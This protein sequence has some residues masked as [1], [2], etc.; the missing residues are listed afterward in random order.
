MAY[1][2]SSTR[3]KNGRGCLTGSFG[4]GGSLGLSA[5]PPPPGFVVVI[6]YHNDHQKMKGFLLKRDPWGSVPHLMRS[7]DAIRIVATLHVLIGGI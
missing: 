6:T 7:G 5:A 1:L 3:L 4:Q 2:P